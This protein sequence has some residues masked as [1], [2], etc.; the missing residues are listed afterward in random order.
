MTGRQPLPDPVS[1]DPLLVRRAKL[2]KREIA[3]AIGIGALATFAAVGILS[4]GF[5][6][7]GSSF[8]EIEGLRYSQAAPGAQGD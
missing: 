3:I 2:R 5:G 1:K 7:P 8:E 6:G 4:D